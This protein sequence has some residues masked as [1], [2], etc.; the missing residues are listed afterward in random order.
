MKTMELG[1]LT[2]RVTGGTDREGGGAGPVVVLMH[3]FGAPGDDLVGLW[4]VLDVPSDV[5]FVFPVAPLALDLGMGD[6]RAWWHLDMERVE[7]AM[8]EGAPRDLSTEAPEGLPAARRAV[9]AMLD[10]LAPALDPEH[11]VLGGFSQGAMLA[12]DVALHDPRALSGL[13]LMSGALLDAADWVPR[14]TTRAGTQV[15]MS[16]GQQDPLLAFE[17]AERL[18]D[19][20]EQAGLHV[21]FVPFRGGH[22]IPQVVL[23]QLEAF[24]RERFA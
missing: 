1:P 8:L 7:R 3:G 13:V 24:L 16:H 18:R 19:R 23:G 4:R 12:M 2:V 17:G 14:M 22:E 15:L 9:R 11:L 20:L 21:R 5:R 10:A 6:A